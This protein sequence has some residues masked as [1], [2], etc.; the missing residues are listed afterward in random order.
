MHIT[1]PMVMPV[2]ICLVAA[3]T[4]LGEVALYRYY[5]H[6]ISTPMTIAKQLRLR[7]LRARLSP[8]TQENA[9]HGLAFLSAGIAAIVIPNL[10]GW[11]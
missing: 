5:S 4:I 7:R 8:D 2:L 1:A 10:L 6:Q 3:V 9:R 11:V